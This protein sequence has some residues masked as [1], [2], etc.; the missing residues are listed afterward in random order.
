MT[1]WRYPWNAQQVQSSGLW[2]QSQQTVKQKPYEHLNRGCK[3]TEKIQPPFMIK[4][5][6]TLGV[7]GNFFTLIKGTYKTP[8]KK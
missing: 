2:P 3:N 6:S 4:T 7:E 1:E 8:Q 5:L